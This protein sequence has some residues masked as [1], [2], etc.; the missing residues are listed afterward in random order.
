MLKRILVLLTCVYAA[1]SSLFAQVTTSSMTGVVNDN[2]NQPMVGA[3]ITAIHQPT[4]TKYATV[5]RSNGNF[6]IQDMRPGGPYYVEVSFVGFETQKFS[7]VYLKL[8]EA[9]QLTVAMPKPGAVLETVVLSAT[10]RRNP[11]FNSGRTGA[12]TNLNRAQIERMP[13]ITRSVNDLTRATPQAS[14]SSSGSIA[15]GNYRQNNFTI[16]GS[17]FNN[18]FGI[19]GNL[20]AGGSPISLDAIDEIS[21]NISPFDIRQSGFIGSAIN[22]VTRSGTNT[23]QGS[24]Y[25]YWRN[26]KQQGDRVG[27]T[28]FVRSPFKYKQW[29]VRFGGPIIK[30]KVFFFFNYETDNTPKFIQTRTAATAANPFS[31]SNPNVAR[32]TADSLNLISN[33]LRTEYGYETGPYDNYTTEII[34]KKILGRI[35]WNISQSNRLS[36]RYSQVEGGEPNPPSTST[37]GSNIVGVTGTRN[38]NNA[39]W[40]SNSNYFQGAN[41]YSLA[42]E[43]TS[44]LGRRVSNVLRGT[45]TYQ[46][47]SRSV[48][49][50]VFPFVDIL[51]GTSTYTSFGHE[52][53]SFGNLRKVKM[54]SILDNITWSK[55]KHTIT[56]GLQADVSKTINGFQRFGTSYYVFNSWNDFVS[57]AKPFNY[58]TTFS[59]L[60][61]FAQ[62]FPSFK[63]AQFA[64]YAQDEI[65]VNRKFKLTLGLRLDQPRYLDVPE[66]KTNPFILAANFRDGIKLN[67]GILPK[68]TIMASPRIGFNYDVYGDRSMQIRGGLGIFTGKVPFVWIV[69][70]SGDNGMLQTTLGINGT[71]NTPG[72]FNP[73]PAAYRP[74]TIP[75]AGSIIP[76][77][78][79][80]LVPDYKFPQTWKTSLGVDAK[81]PG[82][83]VLTIEGI[84]TKDMKTSLFDNVNLIAPTAMSI[85]G[86]PD[87][88]MIWPSAVTAKF[89][90]PVRTTPGQITTVVFVPNGSTAASPSSINAANVIQMKNG[91][92]GHYMSLS[93]QLSKP[94]GKW[95][96]ANVSYTKSFANNLFDGNGDQPLSAWQGTATSTNPNSPVLSY[97]NYIVPDRISAGLNFRFEYFKH[98]ATT[99]SVFYDG[100]SS[101]GRFSYA[102]SGDFN[103]DGVTGNDLIYIPKNASEIS[104][105]GTTTPGQP[106]TYPNGVSYTAQQMSDL[107][108]Q[109]IDQ[110]P[111]LRKHKG[112]Y[113]ERNGAKFPWRNQVDIR[114]MQDLFQNIGKNRNTIQFSIDIFNFGNLLNSDW[115]KIKSLNA[116]SG[117]ILVP[118]NQASIVPGG[119]IV[120]TFRLATDRNNPILT[121]F[122]DNVSITSTYFM[123]FGIRYL[124]N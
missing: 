86:Y 76:T 53:F 41:F 98:L 50:T 68:T 23:F 77:T 83:A 38:D 1:G 4:G 119:T 79:E 2:S 66:I 5:S 75:V 112:Q 100:S 78:I 81:L 107:F 63:F 72:P 111:Y 33:Y 48:N 123:Q 11:I 17:D 74:T 60:P 70:Q 97:A 42:V 13:S 56:A 104:F 64:V 58:A 27:K 108:F 24:V 120:P 59:L 25:Q 52:L 39:M 3:T 55:G 85:S 89:V 110:D 95:L 109:Y 80:A 19:G 103:N 18:S 92:K 34:H 44:K 124:F 57:G 115:G 14:S 84:Y 121:T 37:S 73:N 29:G 51:S 32:P 26:E 113:A 61:G 116:T 10:G 54:Y 71:A 46:N 7:D 31:A 105:S 90:N 93:A 96:T 114:F 35:D 87:T 40:F 22:A 30:N 118:T 16:D 117:Q 12:T 99:I 62:A 28:T 21:V 65:A 94:F 101:G 15:G 49:S 88:R 91:S 8:A 20:P 106:F 102:Y 69:S 47:D 9:Y 36:V 82:N 67:T 45:Y 6:N 122:R 43:L